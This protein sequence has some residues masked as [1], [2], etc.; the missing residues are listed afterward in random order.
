MISVRG[1]IHDSHDVG[2]CTINRGNVT[3]L[4]HFVVSYSTWKS[5]LCFTTKADS[6]GLRQFGGIR[7]LEAYQQNEVCIYWCDKKVESH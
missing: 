2:L 6:P 3:V 5:T 4:L 1:N 7:L